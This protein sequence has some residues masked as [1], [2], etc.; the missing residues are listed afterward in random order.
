MVG[1]LLA[2]A[3][4][5]W[6]SK[7]GLAPLQPVA[8]AAGRITASRMDERL[9]V[10]TVPKE[11]QRLASSYNAMLDRLDGSLY[12]LS[13]FSAD[14]AHDLLTP[15]GN[16]LGE[17]Q[18]ELLRTWEHGRRHL[19]ATVYADPLPLTLAMGNLVVN[20]IDVTPNRGGA[21]ELAAR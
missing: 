8:S 11:R 17:E 16:P 3:L 1:T 20:A 10:G 14:L 5:G 9:D 13:Q 12:G 21:V 15:V 2:G 6:V 4:G 18:I 19:R 7:R